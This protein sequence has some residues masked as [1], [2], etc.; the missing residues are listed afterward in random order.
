M[1]TAQ[2][3]DF[4]SVEDYLVAEELAIS[5]S[6]YINGWVRAMSGAS[7]RH[8]ALKGNCFAYFHSALRGQ[9]CRPCDSE[10][11]LRLRQMRQTRFYYPDVQVVCDSN[12]PTD[13]YQDHPV[14]IIEVLSPSTR[15]NDLDE[16]LNAYLSIP[17]L[18]Y[19]IILE[20]HMPFA[21]VMRR[22]I[23]GF[24]RETH[25]EIDAMIELLMIA[26]KLPLREVYNGIE[27]TPTCVQKSEEICE[28]G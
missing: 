7:L 6:E 13:V 26:C 8:N 20:Q 27:F 14:L 21:I 25:E 23:D 11:K 28:A 17:S 9:R 5:K 4:V 1:S 16:K 19:Y 10:T 22:T 3:P 24:L 2:Q 15:A 18:Q 12:S